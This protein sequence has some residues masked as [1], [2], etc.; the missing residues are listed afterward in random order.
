MSVNTNLDNSLV[1]QPSR[2]SNISQIS[3]INS[4]DIVDMIP[5]QATGGVIV[6]TQAAYDIL[7]SGET[8]TLYVISG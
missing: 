5:F 2:D 4:G 6:L 8:N 3:I 1:N 7:P